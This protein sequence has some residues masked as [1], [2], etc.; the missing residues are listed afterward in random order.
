MVV[1]SDVQVLT[2]E[3]V[4]QII[5]SLIELEPGSYYGDCQSSRQISLN[6]NSLNMVVG[7]KEYLPK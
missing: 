5:I 4:E 6:I 1:W 3:S 7:K 2:N